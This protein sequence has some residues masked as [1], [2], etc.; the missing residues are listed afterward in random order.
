MPQGPNSQ[1]VLTQRGKGTALLPVHASPRPK[2]TSWDPSR[3]RVINII[4]S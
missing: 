2:R 4:Y 3:W 1:Q